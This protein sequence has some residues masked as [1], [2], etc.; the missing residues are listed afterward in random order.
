VHVRGVSASV[1]ALSLA[2][3]RA[4]WGLLSRC[5]EKGINSL[6]VRVQL[7]DALVAPVFGYCEEVW[8]PTLLKSCRTPDACLANELQAM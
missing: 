2:R 4:M 5:G 3:R 1:A 6:A 7:F 8:G